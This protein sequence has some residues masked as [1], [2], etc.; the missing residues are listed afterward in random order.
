MR[1]PRQ[2]HGASR[3]YTCAVATGIRGWRNGLD[4]R[5]A[6]A[7]PKP[8]VP[9]PDR[10]RR[11]QARPRAARQRDALRRPGEQDDPTRSP[12]TR[13]RA[14][15]RTRTAGLFLRS[16]TQ[17]TAIGLWMELLANIAAGRGRYA[18]TSPASRPCDPADAPGQEPAPGPAGPAARRRGAARQ[19]PRPGDRQAARP[20]RPRTWTSRSSST[21]SA[22]RRGEAIWKALA[23]KGWIA[24][25]QR[26]AARRPS[27]GT[28]S[29]ADDH[30]DGPLS[31][32]CDDD[33]QAEGHGRSST[34]AW[35][36]SCSATTPTSP[37]RPPRRS[38]PCC[39]RRSRTGRRPPPS[40]GSWSSSSTTSGAG[41]PG[42]TTP[43]A[44][45]FYFGWDATQGPAVR[46]GGPGGQVGHRPHGLPGQR[47]PR[48]GHVRRLRLRAAR[49]TRSRTSA[50]R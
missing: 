30:F 39:A 9:L 27:S 12:A 20:A 36:W 14:G 23:A 35:S 6:R 49:S 41:T 21:S 48:P 15:T 42:C 47:V 7:P 37:P 8:G 26:T 29:T 50:S 1:D 31:R 32:Y 45:L 17:L 28:A 5:P 24:P 2:R 3:R 43:K 33:D 16:F 44:G 19:L 13:S 46:L 18:R 38:G 4:G 11:A 22:G 40:G 34:G 25:A 10:P